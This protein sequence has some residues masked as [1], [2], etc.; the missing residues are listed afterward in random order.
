MEVEAERVISRLSVSKTDL[1]SECR[2]GHQK[3]IELIAYDRF[4]N[5]IQNV[6]PEK[7]DLS[8]NIV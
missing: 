8:Q 6:E 4:N 5:V 7:M 3:T 2:V 1:G